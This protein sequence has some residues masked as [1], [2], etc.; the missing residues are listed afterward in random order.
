MSN[1]RF[2]AAAAALAAAMPIGL[3]AEVVPRDPLDGSLVNPPRRLQTA[4]ASG[5]RKG[6]PRM[7][8]NKLWRKACE[9]KLGLRR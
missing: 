8:G 9:G 5:R 3:G 2:L 6:A 4:G 7:A 1:V